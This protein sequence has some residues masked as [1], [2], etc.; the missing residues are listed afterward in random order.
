[1]DVLLH[2]ALT[3]TEQKRWQPKSAARTRHRYA[4]CTQRKSVRQLNACI[5]NYLRP[6]TLQIFQV[7]N[8]WLQAIFPY[9][10]DVI[11]P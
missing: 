11:N 9:T 4:V 6:Q 3:A 2:L 7:L 10:F 1:V 8:E 5:R